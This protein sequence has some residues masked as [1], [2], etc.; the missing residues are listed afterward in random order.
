MTTSHDISD[1][2][3][4]AL[5]I[6]EDLDGIQGTLVVLPKSLFERKWGQ[7]DL[8]L[9][10]FMILL[11]VVRTFWG[12]NTRMQFRIENNTFAMG[13][14]QF[15]YCDVVDVERCKRF[16]QLSGRMVTNGFCLETKDGALQMWRV[17]QHH[18]SAEWLFQEIWK[19]VDAAQDGTVP[20]AL[21][22]LTKQPGET[23][24]FTGLANAAATTQT[25]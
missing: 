21:T 8:V 5:N 10:V 25:T 13:K 23:E 12:G 16:D 17:D 18:R 15:R 6:R 3:R 7:L 11:S 9:F 14:N 19:R 20:E 4:E 22:R 1:D 24:S 2:I